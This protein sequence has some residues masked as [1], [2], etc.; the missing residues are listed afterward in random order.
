MMV[1]EFLI[2]LAT[3][4]LIPIGFLDDE[5]YYW[6]ESEPFS[7]NFEMAG[8]ESIFLLANI[9]FAMYIIYYH[10]L[11]ALIHACLHKK[12]NTG[13]CMSRLHKRIG[14]YLYWVGFNRLFMELFF[15]LALLS[16]LNLHTV[17]WST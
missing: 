4:N 9:G 5:K 15:D 13:T 11:I 3:F 17:D 12:R 1:I 7:V 6:P 10:I 2:K 16:I 14:N 8:T